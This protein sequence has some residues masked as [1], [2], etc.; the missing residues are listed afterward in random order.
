MKTHS[1][2]DNLP[3]NLD[4]PNMTNYEEAVRDYKLTIPVKFN[5]GFDV[6]DRWA[7][8]RT[9]LAMVWADRSGEKVE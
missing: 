1:P 7:Q 8:D 5:F 3:V 4:G 6:I 9:K 2:Y